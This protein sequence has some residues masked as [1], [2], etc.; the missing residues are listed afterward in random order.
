MCSGPQGAGQLQGPHTA[1]HAPLRCAQHKPSGGK[2]QALP[3]GLEGVLRAGANAKSL[4]R[5]GR[6][7]ASPSAGYPA[8]TLEA[9]PDNLSRTQGT[10][11]IARC[12]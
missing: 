9:A 8:Q 5:T 4:A 3:A 11:G 1:T 12:S 6:M 10:G 7:A 2:A